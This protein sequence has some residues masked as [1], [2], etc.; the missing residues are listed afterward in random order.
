MT[1]SRGMIAGPGGEGGGATPGVGGAPGQG[2]EQQPM[3]PTLAPW[4]DPANWITPVR[5]SLPFSPVWQSPSPRQTEPSRA[6]KT[7]DD[8]S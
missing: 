1:T 6:R 5:L 7:L 8:R 2:Q 4:R 3:A